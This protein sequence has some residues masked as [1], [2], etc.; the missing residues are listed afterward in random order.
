VSEA[1]DS[2][3]NT[4]RRVSAYL[5]RYKAL[6][7][8]TIALAS[9]AT[10]LEIT[11]PM[12]VKGILDNLSTTQDPSVLTKG[13]FL[14][15]IFLVGSELL[16]RSRIRVN[17]TLEQRVLLEM[18]RDL[19][20]KLLRLPVSF[21][22][23]RKSGEISSRVIEDVAAVERAL[24]D[25]TEQGT[26]AAIRIILISAYLF[27]LQ[28]FLACFVFL[29]VPLLLVVGILYSKNSRIIWKDVR[30]SAGDLNSLLV[31]DI[32]GNRLI[33]TFGL[34]DRESER[35]EEKAENLRTKTVRA[36]YRWANYHPF[37]NL[38]TK[39]G[40]PQH[41]RDRRLSRASGQR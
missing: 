22:D 34:Q 1:T 35:F 17:N 16:N 7:W 2:S 36:M 18:R 19:H 23:Q 30:K 5:F 31:E 39:F 33:Q 12:F 38:V 21:Y 26:S 27:Y 6:F 28:P 20:T 32:Q 11:V 24:L 15:G 13:V 29:P 37:T 8:T 9:G 14:I 40:F 41:R 4:I 3:K 25:G 10:I